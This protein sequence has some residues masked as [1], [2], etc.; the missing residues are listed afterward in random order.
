MGKKIGK[1]IITGAAGWAGW[2]IGEG[3]WK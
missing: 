2:E 3:I 1:W